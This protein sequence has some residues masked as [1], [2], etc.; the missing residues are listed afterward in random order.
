MIVNSDVFLM[1][2]VVDIP[3]V[4]LARQGQSRAANRGPIDDMKQLVRVSI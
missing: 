1:P 3:D 2:D 4:S